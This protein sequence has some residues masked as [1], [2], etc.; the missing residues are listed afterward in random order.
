MDFKGHLWLTGRDS[1]S[2]AAMTPLGGRGRGGIRLGWSAIWSL[3]S[4]ENE[5]P[6]TTFSRFLSRIDKKTECADW[7]PCVS[8]IVCVCVCEQL[9]RKVAVWSIMVKLMTKQLAQPI[10]WRIN[11]KHGFE[12]FAIKY[13]VF[14]KFLVSRGG[15]AVRGDEPVPQIN[16]GK[17]AP[18][19]RSH[20]HISQSYYKRP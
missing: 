15:A 11:G 19:G 9:V 18:D 20:Y 2:A 3:I 10:N 16:E 5:I 14:S 7:R 1:I 8:Q 17:G 12:P 13:V 4:A 6:L